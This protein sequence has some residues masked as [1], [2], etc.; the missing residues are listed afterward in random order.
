MKK[1]TV[2]ALAM[3]A[4][5]FSCTHSNENIAP[6]SQKS[7]GLVIP[8]PASELSSNLILLKDGRIADPV[9]GISSFDTIPPGEKL[10]LSF[11]TGSTHDGVTE[12]HVTQFAS[13]QDSS[14]IPEPPVIDST[15]FTGAFSGVAYRI[16][17]D[18]SFINSGNTSI[19]F[20]SPNKYT[21]DGVEGGY[22]LAGS[23]TFVVSNGTITFIDSNT[24]S[25]AML[26]GS[27]SFSLNSGCLY[28]WA[29]RT[30][31]LYGGPKEKLLGYSLR[32]D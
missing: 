13:A 24:D 31:T 25:D 32:R 19:H 27:F 28:M 15:A 3:F 4:L 7:L 16:A 21:C 22:P 30:E 29:V 14:F 1:I 26:N 10:S 9:S 18:S 23:G 11:T 6:K 17:S 5:L 20:T 12:I 2:V 8:R